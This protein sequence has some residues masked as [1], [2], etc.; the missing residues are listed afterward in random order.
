M[1]EYT[2]LI[3][4]DI[5]V[6]IWRD[7]TVDIHV[8]ETKTSGTTFGLGWKKYQ[9]FKGKLIGSWHNYTVTNPKAG[10]EVRLYNKD[11]KHASLPVVVR[12]I[13]HNG[14]PMDTTS[15]WKMVEENQKII[16][17]NLGFTSLD[18]EAKYS[19]TIAR[20][21]SLALD[22]NNDRIAVSQLVSDRYPVN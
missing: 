13:Y 7:G 19:V 9:S 14:N 16:S 2:F 4:D 10:Q 5:P 17:Y 22:Q 3:L 12:A 6:T 15:I 8:P 1:H 20:F 11:A 18:E 21:L